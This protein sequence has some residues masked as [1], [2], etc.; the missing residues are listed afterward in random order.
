MGDQDNI[1]MVTMYCVGQATHQSPSITT[2]KMRSEVGLSGWPE[3]T[4]GFNPENTSYL[5]KNNAR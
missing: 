3:Q 2:D 4:V 5:G 1:K